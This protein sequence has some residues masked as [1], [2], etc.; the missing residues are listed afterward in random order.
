MS[1]EWRSSD[2]D[3]NVVLKSTKIGLISSRPTCRFGIIKL[4]NIFVFCSNSPVCV[5]FYSV[6]YFN[7]MFSFR[8]LQ[9]DPIPSATISVGI[10]CGILFDKMYFCKI[11]FVAYPTCSWH[12]HAASHVL[13]LLIGIT[14]KNRQCLR[15]IGLF[16]S[17]WVS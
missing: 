9:S 16:K 6:P 2:F 12:E 5:C 7:F 3:Q 11:T 8:I 15:V 13:N 14:S 17:I 10:V 4:F 1:S